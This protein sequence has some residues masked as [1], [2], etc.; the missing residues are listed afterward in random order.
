M[1]FNKTK[2]DGLIRQTFKY[3]S[4]DFA[5][6][7]YQFEVKI[8]EI[9]HQSLASATWSLSQFLSL[10]LGFYFMDEIKNRK[11]IT[12]A[13]CN[14]HLLPAIPP[15]TEN[16]FINPT[17]ALVK[18]HQSFC[19]YY[20]K[21]KQ[22][23]S[24]IATKRVD[25]LSTLL[26]KLSKNTYK[27]ITTLLQKQPDKLTKEDIKILD[28]FHGIR[29]AIIKYH[30][31]TLDAY[32]YP[33]SCSVRNVNISDLPTIITEMN[34]I[35]TKKHK[36][37]KLL[38]KNKLLDK[39]TPYSWME[40]A[41]EKDVFTVETMSGLSKLIFPLEIRNAILFNHFKL[42][43]SL[44]SNGNPRELTCNII[45]AA[46][47]LTKSL[48]REV[49]ETSVLELCMKDNSF[50][51]YVDR[52]K[53]CL[54]NINLLPRSIEAINQAINEG[55]ADIAYKYCFSGLIRLLK[56]HDNIF[57]GFIA[58]QTVK[59][60]RDGGEIVITTKIPLLA[61][62]LSLSE[63][64]LG[65]SP[66]AKVDCKTEI[67]IT[68]DDLRF[69]EEEL[70][71]FAKRY[72]KQ[73]VLPLEVGNQAPHNPN[74][75][76][77]KGVWANSLG[78]LNELA[79]NLQRGNKYESFIASLNLIF[80]TVKITHP[81]FDQMKMPGTVTDFHKFCLSITGARGLFPVD[82]RTFRR[83]CKGYAQGADKAAII[84]CEWDKAARPCDFWKNFLPKMTSY[85]VTTMQQ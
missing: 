47:I 82:K 77:T 36:V 32:R 11:V 72:L 9:F 22:L 66:S 70:I 63:W 78:Q 76:D 5:K 53:C 19:L 39:I 69:R 41:E 50:S 64:I 26:K 59:H 54:R 60:L 48:K 20:F 2:L 31:T 4:K 12:E 15:D 33:G 10:I 62:Q 35:F 29:K 23:I 52:A 18:D 28:I 84:L 43:K 83:Y 80:A 85:T 61:F 6:A 74:R 81:D 17:Y 65:Y 58:Q 75:E 71:E 38:T 68:K 42:D 13:P 25:G 30:A 3:A 46:K 51:V 7:L 40:L 73:E 1:D 44:A 14:F 67:R 57:D 55:S 16:I 79:R 21:N 49:D 37:L 27:E 8:N 56:S 45:S 24:R 34:T